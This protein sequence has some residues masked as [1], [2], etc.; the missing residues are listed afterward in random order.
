[1]RKTPPTRRPRPRSPTRSPISTPPPP[2]N[3]NTLSRPSHIAAPHYPALITTAHVPLRTPLP[4]QTPNTSHLHRN[5]AEELER[6]GR[7]RLLLVRILTTRRRKSGRDQQ[8]LLLVRRRVLEH[9]DARAPAGGDRHIARAGQRADD[10]LLRSSTLA[11]FS[12]T[13]DSSFGSCTR[14][15]SWRRGAVPSGL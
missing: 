5:A 11:G 2:R 4:Q 7:R 14:P 12:S 10:T 9:D 6:C 8:D 13:S 15:P 3:A 1:M